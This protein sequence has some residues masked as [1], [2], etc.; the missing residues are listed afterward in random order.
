MPEKAEVSQEEV[1]HLVQ[2]TAEEKA[3]EKRLVRKVDARVMPLVILVY[4]MNYVD[5]NNYAAAKLQGLTEDLH[6]NDHQYQ[7]GLSIL[8]VGY[9]LMQIPSNLLLN[10][11]GRPSVYIGTCVCVWGLV[12]A[13][14]SQV[15]SY[16]GI[17]AC[18]FL[19]GFV[20]AP[21]FGGVLFYLSKWYTRSELSFRMSIFYSG[22]LLSGAFGN[23]IAAGILEGLAGKRGMAA[24]RWLYI[25]E[26]SVTCFFGLL[27]CFFLPDFPDTWR[28]L[29]EENRS[30]LVRR[31]AIEAAEADVD[32]A[33]GMSQ[34]AGLK[35]AVSDEKT[36]AFALAYMAIAAAGSFQYFF[37]TLTRTLHYSNTISLLLVAPPYVFTVF[38]TLAHNWA[39]DRLA[40][41]FWFFVYPIPITIVGFV[42]FMTVDSFGPRYFS[43]FLMNAT[44]AQNGILYSWIASSLPRPPAKRAAAYG[45]INMIANSASIWTPY[46]YFP[47]EAPYYRVAL[48]VC[49]AAQVIGGLAAL[50]VY[51]RLRALN[52]RQARLDD[53]EVTLS[54]REMRRLETTARIEGI[55]VAAARR[56]QKGFRYML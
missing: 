23:L 31:L 30:I 2:L 20:E 3:L 29:S 34:I 4:L 12:S 9:L 55:D 35:M 46:T 42:I 18:R 37:P 50:F 24:W 53:D 43:F 17:V 48:A 5:R 16:G 7:T 36:W 32:D 13:L 49:I 25:V 40:K 8:F 22:S 51:V 44:F 26:G 39:S 45:L 11:M 27:V 6:M 28:A 41:R 14:T 47:S 56:L 33:G 38:Y 54:E 15:Q 21:F 19:L 10:Y 1:V 52:A